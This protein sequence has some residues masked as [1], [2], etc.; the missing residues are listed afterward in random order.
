MEQIARDRRAGYGFS[1]LGAR[2][3]ERERL[4][5][6][7]RRARGLGWFSIGLGIA[8]LTSPRAMSSLVLGA[9][10]Q[11][12]R[13]AM[14]LVG[15]RELV[16]GI[17]ILT[18]RH[19]SRWLWMRVLGDVMDLALLGASLSTR[20]TDKGRVLRSM[21]GVLGLTALD[22]MASLRH[23][24]AR[25]PLDVQRFTAAV[26]VN[27]QPEEVYGFW[28][29]LQNLPRFM[30][31]LE[32]VQIRD[33]RRSRWVARGPGR[34]RIEWEAEITEDQRNERI[35]WRSVEGSQVDNAG[36]VS[37]R[38]APGGRGT[39]VV[40]ELEYLPP[41]GLFALKLAR[42]LGEAPRQKAASDL[43]R[44]KQVVE[45]GEVL[46]SDASIH[47]GMHPARPPRERELPAPGGRR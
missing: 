13:R 7:V 29:N 42:L 40:L 33:D 12:R 18:Q 26:T 4:S 39:E 16:C 46:H 10:N 36:T 8:Q 2:R 38:P 32:S 44:F 22:T 19:P 28:R 41:R 24:R 3:R 17:G 37:F 35:S 31:H 43:R 23:G 6:G 11:R 5:S 34:S 30:A 45:T 9:D 15:A 47:R 1:A 27:R 14:R 21:A 20:R 25:A